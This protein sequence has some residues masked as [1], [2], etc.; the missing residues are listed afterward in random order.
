[1]DYHSILD[2]PSYL[3]N[4]EGFQEARRDQ[5]L[6]NMLLKCTFQVGLLY[7]EIPHHCGWLF[8]QNMLARLLSTSIYEQHSLRIWVQPC[9]D[10]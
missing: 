7:T 10:E 1:M 3:C 6:L 4:H 8:G 2:E 9:I 5:S